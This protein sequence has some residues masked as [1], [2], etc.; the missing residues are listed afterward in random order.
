M[1]I[2]TKDIVKTA[3]Q[4]SVE[5]GVLLREFLKELKKNESDN[6]E[7]LKIISSAL[8]CQ[9]QVWCKDV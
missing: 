6:L 7:L 4:A 9:G 1:Q 5:F 3:D 8:K 2:T